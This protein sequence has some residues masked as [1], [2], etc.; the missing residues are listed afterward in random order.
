MQMDA[1]QVVVGPNPRVGTCQNIQK[2]EVNPQTDRQ[3]SFKS[4]LVIWGTSNA[5]YTKLIVF[6]VLLVL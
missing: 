4:H 5:S 2:L 6:Q 1:L 3:G